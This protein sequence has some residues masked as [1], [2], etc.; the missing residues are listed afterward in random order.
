[1]R[2]Q[3]NQ[4][5]NQH[6]RA[7]YFERPLFSFAGEASILNGVIHGYSISVS[8]IIDFIL[9]SSIYSAAYS[10]KG[11]NLHTLHTL[12]RVIIISRIERPCACLWSVGSTRQKALAWGRSERCCTPDSEFGFLSG[13]TFEVSPANSCFLQQ[14][15]FATYRVEMVALYTF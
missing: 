1:M 12:S 5:F 4:I 8:K 10:I 6:K 13:K 3:I 2:L 14:F 7:F 9:D 15:W 11:E